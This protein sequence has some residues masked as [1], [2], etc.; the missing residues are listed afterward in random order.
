[1]HRQK[2]KQ[3]DSPR[4]KE[5]EA[6]THVHPM[7]EDERSIVTSAPGKC[8]LFGEHA[9][10]YGQP[11]VAVAIEQRLTVTLSPANSWSVDGSALHPLKHPHITTLRDLYLNEQAAPLAIHIQADIPRASGLGSSAALSAAVG[12][13]FHALTYPEDEVDRTLLSERA[14]QAE[15]QA[16]HGRASPMDTST[17]VEGGVVVLSNQRESVGTWAYTRTLTTPEGERSWQVHRLEAP[18]DAVFLVLG[19]T[20][21]HAPTAHQVAMVAETLRLK[22]ERMNEIEAIGSVARRGLE[23]LVAGEYEAVGH[24]M[25]ENHLL[26]RGLGVSSPELENLIQAALPTSLGVKLTGAGGGGCMVALTRQP[27]ET[28]EAIE[29]AG[30]RTLISRIGN[31]GVRLERRT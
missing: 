17:S 22:P 14:H 8:I 29:L 23:A 12:A 16:Q 1:M 24:A 25:S 15:A 30:G 2:H 26:L 7:G 9:V 19:N 4:N 21:I 13:A 11:A 5:Y 3:T 18:P 28:S 27:K 31:V 10:V 6:Q 20:G